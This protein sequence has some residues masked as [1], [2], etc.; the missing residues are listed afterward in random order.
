MMLVLGAFAL[1][2]G[3][4]ILTGMFGVG[5][6]F[7]I[8]P[9]LNVLLGIPMPIAVGTSTI[10]ILG[11]STAGLYRKHSEGRTDY[12]MA[13]MLFGGN[14][15]GV[16][17]GAATLSWLGAL[18]ALTLSGKTVALVDFVVLCVFLVLLGFITVWLW[19]DASRRKPEQTQYQGLFARIKLP[20]YTN[21]ETLDSPQLSIIV[22][23][24]LGLALGFLTG[25]LGI[26]GGVVLVPAL[27]Y[28]IGMRPHWA[29]ATSLAMVWL[30]SFLGVI[31][32]ASAGH[33]NLALAIPMLVGGSVGVQIGGYLCNLCN[34][35]ALQRYFSLVVLAAL[36]LIA[37][38]LVALVW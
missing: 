4:G 17:L 38:K 10:Q 30:T 7:L 21:F 26:G 12:K 16:R 19:Y 27:V 22:M 3:V 25:L 8:T 18:G 37:G 24:Y 14:L 28:L 23:S 13:L 1:S 31:A 2:L 33:A 5:G 15:V 20:P 32:H 35:R 29:S 6:G 9:L 36:V 34:A 11:V